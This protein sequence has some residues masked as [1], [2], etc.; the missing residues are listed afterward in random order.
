MAYLEEELRKEREERIAT[1]D[2]ELI[3]IEKDID[4]A[5]LDLEA[6]KNGRVNKEREIIELL[7]DEAS[8]VEDS[9]NTEKEGRLEQQ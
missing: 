4:Q 5:N 2:E 9:I 7:A 1:L 8:K 6:E 3:P